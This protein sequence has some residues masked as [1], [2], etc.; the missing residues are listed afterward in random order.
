[1]SICTVTNYKVNCDECISES[2]KI[3][4]EHDFIN[5]NIEYDFIFSLWHLFFYDS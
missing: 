3:C 5:M 1:M 4:Q 2:L